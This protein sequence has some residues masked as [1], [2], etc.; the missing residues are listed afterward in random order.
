MIHLSSTQYQQT[1]HAIP[2]DAH[3]SA[4][5][6]LPDD[7]RANSHRD[8]FGDIAARF[9]S[10]WPSPSS[11]DAGCA[12]G[13]HVDAAP[14][15]SQALNSKCA[16]RGLGRLTD[17]IAG[18]YDLIACI[19]VL[20]HLPR[21]E[22]D[23]A[24]RNI[25]AATTRILFSAS[26]DDLAG[27]AHD[28]ARAPVEWLHAFAEHG[29][30]PVACFDPSFLRPWAIALERS[31]K[32]RNDDLLLVHAELVASRIEA[33]KNSAALKAELAAAHRHLR[34]AVH[35]LA[36]RHAALSAKKP[37]I[38]FFQRFSR[39]HRRLRYLRQSIFFDPGWYT[40][41]YGDLAEDID[42]AEHYMTTGRQEGRDPGPVF[43]A[44]GYL[45]ANS[46]V[47]GTNYDPLVHFER[48]GKYEG[49]RMAFRFEGVEPLAFDMP[50]PPA[51]KRRIW[52][53]P[54][55]ATYQDW[56][57]R[58]D[59]LDDDDRQAILT[60]VETLTYQPLISVIMPVYETPPAL[61][62]Q[63]LDSVRA[64]IYPH[65]ELCIAD[66]ASPSPLVA[67]IL[68]DYA[69]RDARI[70]IMRREVNGHI[71]A[72][73]NSALQLARGEFIAL[74]DHDDLLAEHGLYHVVVELNRTPDADLIY[75]DEDRVDENGRR[76]DPYF[77]TDWNPELFLGHNI[78]SHLGVYR[79]SL[80][81]KIGGLRL[82]LE[83]S[84][85]YDLAL[86][87]S[88]ETSPD[89]IRHIPAILYHWR[90]STMKSS[91][92]ES[93]LQ[94]CVDAARR[95][96]A[97]HLR[98]MGD[99]SIVEPHPFLPQ[100]ER[101]RRMVPSPA[102]LVSLIV[103]TRNRADLLRP[104]LDGLMR[105]TTYP[106]LE[107]IVIDHDSD[108]P[109]TRELLREVALDPRVRVMPYRGAFNYSDMN[110]KAVAIAQGELIGL[111]NNDIDVIDPD[112]LNEMAALASR[113]E[114]GVV[115]AKLLYPDGS[116]QHAGVVLGVGGVAAHLHS[117][118]GAKDAGYFGR[119][120]LASNVSAVTGACLVVRKAVYEE[121]GGLNAAHLA[122]AFNDVDFSLKVAAKGYRNVWTPFALL[123]HHES[124][125]RGTDLQ[126]EKAARFRQEVFYMQRT[127][128]NI[129][130][131][132]P[133][134]NVN[135]SLGSSNFELVIP[136]RRPKP[137]MASSPALAPWRA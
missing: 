6:H 86:R 104:C 46:D 35:S 37:R 108:E 83:G 22:A 88:R 70:R 45:Q 85:D 2:D 99:D 129:L 39:F 10:A 77:K 103:P 67:A 32:A 62:R 14:P 87:V 100:W 71:S 42:P 30:A 44:A 40:R 50:R 96:K 130:E 75:S 31:E 18:S 113:P 94:R 111:I 66:D 3:C 21:H 84:Q 57:E 16:F 29:F 134:Y 127:W 56:I 63:A 17:P 41:K 36:T 28:K 131:T 117:G 73:T 53:A 68:A 97:D 79:R 52:T 65:W 48:Y 133:F 33:S 24:I 26:P 115:G 25:C 102:P 98:A 49:R 76:H 51:K 74:M 137:W 136:G 101:V 23:Q 47:L 121:V 128:G 60:H 19:E 80:V 4:Y 122:V 64:Q 91:F 123:F 112:W 9:V 27:P 82:G 8:T 125:S 58:C 118:F 54:G 126:P 12:I 92:S 116:V 13:F 78:V 5:G 135:F 11:F 89:R 7:R 109:E 43:S 38:G 95:A 34:E 105:R 110:N 61:L 120:Q 93:Q 132:D 59:T 72:A 69:A 106:N 124:P 55:A 81:E 20:A 90:S 119:L 15:I 1:R 114:N 107:I